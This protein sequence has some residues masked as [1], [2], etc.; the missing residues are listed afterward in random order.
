MCEFSFWAFIL[1]FTVFSYAT[2]ILKIKALF[3][4]KPSEIVIYNYTGVI[5]S[6]ILDYFFFDKALT[7]T[8]M[9]GLM[10]TSTGIIS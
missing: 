9:M 1:L 5:L 3:I 8:K 2:Q 7:W 4:C 6:L 10:L